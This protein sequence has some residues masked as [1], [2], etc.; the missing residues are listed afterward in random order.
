MQ[1]TYG[2]IKITRY[3][4]F[5]IPYSDIVSQEIFHFMEMFLFLQTCANAHVCLLFW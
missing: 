1:N 3:H 5:F 4:P 2:I